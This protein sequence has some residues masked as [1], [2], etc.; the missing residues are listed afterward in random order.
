MANLEYCK[1][2]G[3]GFE[4]DRNYDTIRDE[5]VDHYVINHSDKLLFKL[6]QIIDNNSVRFLDS[7]LRP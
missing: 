4:M 6:A 3:L 5:I 1:Q 2:C 7:L